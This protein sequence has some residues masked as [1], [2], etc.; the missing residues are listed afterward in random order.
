VGMTESFY[1]LADRIRGGVLGEFLARTWRRLIPPITV[2]KKIYGV[3]ICLDLR[4]HLFWFASDPEK[5]RRS[6]RFHDMIAGIKGPVWDVGCNVGVFSLY[7]ASQGNQVTAFDISPKAIA[8]LNRSAERNQ[9]NVATVGRAFGV[10]TFKYSPPTDADTRNKPGAAGADSETSMTYL[11]AEAQF[12]RPDFI[13]MD[14][15]GAEISFLK[16]EEFRTWIKTN[17]IA[18][19]MELH[20]KGF[21]DILWPDVPHTR[22]DEAHVLFNHVRQP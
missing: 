18:L 12:G 16:S 21:W 7:A 9:L 14:I 20:E 4:D 11:E 13:K 15:E 6:E 17:R 22:F 19:L 3:D 5:I 10:T 2:W 1:A 8:L